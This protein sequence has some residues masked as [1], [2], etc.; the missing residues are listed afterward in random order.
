[1][2]VIL[3]CAMVAPAL[4]MEDQRYSYITVHKMEITVQNNRATITVDYTIDEGIR[5]LVLLLGK[6]DLK[7]KLLKMVNYDNAY[8]EEVGLDHAVIIVDDA[9][10]DYGEGIYWFPEHSFN[11][12]L[13]ELRV[14]T[15]Q[16]IRDYSMTREFS[17]GIGHFQV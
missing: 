9:S 16:T 5:V 15:P 1:M 13:P 17:G 12:L 6:S 10:D 4:A 8:F 11:V 2:L 14:R 7:S 3:I